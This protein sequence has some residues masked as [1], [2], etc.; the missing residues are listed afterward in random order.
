M[1]MGADDTGR[2]ED[3][4]VDKPDGGDTETCAWRVVGHSSG[5]RSG[6]EILVGT[7]HAFDWE[8]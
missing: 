4:D 6:G 7:L 1:G 8:I 2:I 5:L 3:V